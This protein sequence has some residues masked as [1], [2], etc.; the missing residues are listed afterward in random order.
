MLS[1]EYR[2][3]RLVSMNYTSRDKKSL[4][5][6]KRENERY[7]GIDAIQLQNIKKKIHQ[8]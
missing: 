4:L 1:P 7:L 8:N 2:D 6:S 3:T 5:Q